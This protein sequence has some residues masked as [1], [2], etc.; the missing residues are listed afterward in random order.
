MAGPYYVD[1]GAGGTNAGT[2]WTDAFTSFWSLTGLASGEIVYVASRH[3]EANVAAHK[4]LTLPTSGQPVYLYSVTTGT[5]TYAAGAHVKSTGGAYSITID[6]SGEFHGFKF[7]VGTGGAVLSMVADGNERGRCVS[8]TYVIGAAA[9]IALAGNN[10][11]HINCVI[12]LAADTAGSSNSIVTVYAIARD[13]N[14]I[15]L[16]I[17][18]GGNR[19][20][21]SARLWAPSS[22]QSQAIVR[23]DGCDFNS[24]TSACEML[25]GSSIL[26][27][28]FTNC[29]M[30]S[31]WTV[32]NSAITNNSAPVDFWGC[33]NTEASSVRVSFHRRMFSGAIDHDLTVYMSDANAASSDDGT[34]STVAHSWKMVSED[35]AAECDQ[36]NTLYTPWIYTKVTS[37]GSKTFTVYVGAAETLDNAEVWVEFAYLG[38]SGVEVFSRVSTERVANATPATYGTTGGTWNGTV[39]SSY[40]IT[41]GS[42]TVNETGLARARVHVG[43]TSKT[44]Y[45]N[46]KLLV[47]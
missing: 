17:S 21:A 2:S 10:Y 44:V 34:G 11:D 46:P 14:F 9:Q 22:T 36:S 24:L 37:T 1:S 38:T 33:E 41:S 20:G 13:I 18:N 15:N 35:T 26:G 12:D 19:T 3:V 47:A 16:T 8:C 39:T 29:K 25:Y 23:W 4:T 40:P 31:A 42:V 32:L 7:T 30:P 5:T 6:G 43:A 45:V 27:T 28:E